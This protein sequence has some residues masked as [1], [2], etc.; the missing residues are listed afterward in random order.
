MLFRS[1]RET[2]PLDAPPM[3]GHSLAVFEDFDHRR[4]EPHVDLGVHEGMWDGVGVVIDGEVVVDVDLRALP[5][6]VLEGVGRQG[7]QRRTIELLEEIA[8]AR[9][10]V[11]PHRLRVELVEELGDPGVQ[12]VEREEGLVTQPGDDPALD[13]KSVV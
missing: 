6:G 8:S 9:S 4:R 10:T 11:V 2:A 7:P 5:L 1:R 3:D 12:R 13:R